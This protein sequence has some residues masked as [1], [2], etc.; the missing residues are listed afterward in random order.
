MELPC[1]LIPGNTGDT[2]FS[3]CKAKMSTEYRKKGYKLFQEL[4][5]SNVSFFC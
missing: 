4:N 5:I 2:A 3:A 1:C